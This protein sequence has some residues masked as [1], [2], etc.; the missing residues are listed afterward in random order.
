M[1]AL[2]Y[3]FG[4]EE[5]SPSHHLQ[6]KTL[7]FYNCRYYGLYSGRD[8]HPYFINH[9][10]N[11]RCEYTHL[12]PQ[13]TAILDR[14]LRATFSEIL[15]FAKN[16][17]IL[18]CLVPRAKREE[19]YYPE[20]LQFKQVLRRVVCEEQF[21]GKLEDGV[22]CIQRELNTHPSHHRSSSWQPV[23][24]PGT[25][26]EFHPR[27][28]ANT[29]SISPA[30]KDRAIILVD[31]IYTAG[32]GIDEEAIQALYDHGARKVILYTIGKT[33]RA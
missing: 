27:S 16:V 5:L 28:I 19:H 32:V 30:V 24:Q 12:L 7:L 26:T 23:F 15:Q 18:V 17:P 3:A 8:D 31:D 25:P 6:H 2:K 1:E 33:C 14:W 20:Q 11:D 22:D 9:L 21:A 13:A 10:K 29:C 4:V